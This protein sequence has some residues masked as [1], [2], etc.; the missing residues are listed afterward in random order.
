MNTEKLQFKLL[1]RWWQYVLIAGVA[2]FYA[3][4]TEHIWEDYYITYRVSKNLVLGNGLV[5][6]PGERVHVFTSPVNVLVPAAICWATGNRSDRLVIWIFRIISVGL[7]AGTWVNLR[8]ALM[9]WRVFGPPA[10]FLLLLLAFECKIVAF[11]MNGQEAAYMIF[12]LSALI[13][14]F[15]SKS[16]RWRNI[17]WIFA[18]LMYTRPDGFVYG[19]ALTAGFILFPAGENTARERKTLIIDTL[20]GGGLALLIYAPWLIWST[21][22]YGSPIP[23]TVIAKQDFAGI[24]G[25]LNGLLTFPLMLIREGAGIIFL[26]IYHGFGGWPAAVGIFAQFIGVPAALYWILPFAGRPARACSLALFLSY[27]YLFVVASFPAPWYLPSAGLFGIVTLSLMAADLLRLKL[28]LERAGAKRISS[29][30]RA[31][32]VSIILAVWIGIAAIFGMTAYQMRVQ[33]YEI[34]NEVRRAIGIWLKEQSKTPAD[35]VF[36]EPLGYIGFFSELKMYD[37]P[38]LSSPE[39]VATS[40]KLGTESWGP[41]IR[42]LSPEWIV[43]RPPESQRVFREDPTLLEEEYRFQVQFDARHRLN[44]YRWIPGISYLHHDLVFNI[45]RRRAGAVL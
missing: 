25:I 24:T 43:L 35:T 2:V 18:G 12:F 34:E 31:G 38:G 8:R 11:S 16:H 14:S 15:S 19:G 32:S 10:L 9:K 4:Y 37:F 41:I 21:W 36:L 17:G 3:A 33:Q 22:Y 13:L 29:V 42:E 28:R 1:K 20:K 27:I 7:L 6:Q 26:P 40:R 23:H 39:V 44:S 5:Y 30:L 45:Y